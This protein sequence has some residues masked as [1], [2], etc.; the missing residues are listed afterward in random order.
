VEQG[1]IRD[2]AIGFVPGP[3]TSAVWDVQNDQN[4]QVPNTWRLAQILQ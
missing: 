4:Q 1:C 2:P 3:V